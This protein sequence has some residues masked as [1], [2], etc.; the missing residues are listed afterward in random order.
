MVER[1]PRSCRARCKRWH[2]PSPT[3][4]AVPWKVRR[5]ML[6]RKL[7]LPCWWSSS[8]A[9]MTPSQEPN[10][11]RLGR[12]EQRIGS[13]LLDHRESPSAVLLAGDPRLCA[14]ASD[15]LPH[16]IERPRGASQ[17]L[18]S[19]FRSFFLLV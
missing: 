12:G 11:V 16:S 13:A 15:P 17:N 4:S 6:P 10:H 19:M 5:M 8:K 2:S 1:V 14:N 9:E 18:N 3:H 7:L